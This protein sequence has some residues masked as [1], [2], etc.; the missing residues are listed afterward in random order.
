MVIRLKRLPGMTKTSFIDSRVR[1]ELIRYIQQHLTQDECDQFNAYLNTL[2]IDKSIIRVIKIIVREL[3]FY[4]TDD[5]FVWYLPKYIY[6][7]NTSYSLRD[8]AN[9]LD[10]GNTSLKGTRVLSDAARYI[11]DTMYA[12]LII[13]MW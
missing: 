7:D 2:G 13:Q 5:E 11:A 4:C 1:W 10:K 12:K 9:L 6:L 8:I 3:K